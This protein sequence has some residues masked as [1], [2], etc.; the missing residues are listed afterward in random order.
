LAK[1]DSFE[2]HHERY[3]DWFSRH[4]SAYLSELLA[5]RAVMPWQGLG[6]EIGV[7]SGR[8]AAPLGVAVGVD[9]SGAMLGYAARRGIQVV[10]AVTEALPFLDAVFDY[11]LVVTTIC[12]VGDPVQMLAEARRVLRPLANFILPNKKRMSFTGMPH[13]T[14]HLR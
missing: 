1:I 6:M 12:F 14:P 5:L 10:R 11:V 4:E 8:F 2:R 9:P 3:E 13:F 7:G